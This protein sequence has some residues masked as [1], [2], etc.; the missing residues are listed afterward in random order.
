MK[1]LD[2]VAMFLF[3]LWAGE[4]DFTNMSLRDYLAGGILIA[5]IIYYSV[6]QA[7][8]KTEKGKK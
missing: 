1:Y 4:M 6:R 2:F 3:V 5:Y 7:R 8:L